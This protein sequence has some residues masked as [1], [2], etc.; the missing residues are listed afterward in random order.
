M[1]DE[2]ATADPKGLKLDSLVPWLADHLPDAVAPFQFELIAAGG[3]NLTYRFTDQRGVIRILRRPPVR[4][5]IATAHDM[6]REYRILHALGQHPCGVPV[7]A[8][9]GFCEDAEVIGAPFYIMAFLDGLI[10][11]DSAAA[12]ALDAAQ[13][14]AATESLID[15]QV[16]FH[17]LDLEQTGLAGL[18]AHQGYVQRQLNRWRKQAEASKTRELPLMEPLYRRLQK[19]I[20]KEQGRPG[21]AHGDYRF[22]NT[23]LDSDSRIAAVLDWELCTIGEP[24][25]DFCWSLMYWADPD[26]EL[27]FLQDPP[28]RGPQF[29]RRA[30]VAELY[31]RKSGFDLSDLDYYTA[32]SWWKM[33]C[34]VE[35][36][37]ARLKQGAGG[38]MRTGSLDN[39]ARLVD[40]YLEQADRLAPR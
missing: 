29:P 38:G 4:G 16:A 37:Y 39:V 7:P 26:D 2:K 25:A 31:A 5:Q 30:E 18:A 3:S 21:L 24:V 14:R 17:R 13:A 23:I 8:C 28:T 1:P 9:L 20:P 15:V 12:A 10:L 33:A 32:F 40:R 36:V 35:G 34:I 19:H 27:S 6:Q 11:R 22:D